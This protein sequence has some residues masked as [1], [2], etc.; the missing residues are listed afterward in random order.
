[1]R[2]RVSD[3]VT[4]QYRIIYVHWDTDGGPTI[5]RQIYTWHKK[6]VSRTARNKTRQGAERDEKNNQ[7]NMK[8]HRPITT[9]RPSFY[10][11]REYL[12]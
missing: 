5:L 8:K 3:I 6:G 10:S 12:R 2:S 1:M 7:R 9:L 11:R 4:S